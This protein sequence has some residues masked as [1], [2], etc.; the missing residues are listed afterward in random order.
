MAGILS[1]GEP[2]LKV[3]MNMTRPTEI[4]THDKYSDILSVTEKQYVPNLETI[5]LLK[6]RKPLC[7]LLGVLIVSC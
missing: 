7:I 3:Y 4:N 2:C 5:L 1:T 6:S